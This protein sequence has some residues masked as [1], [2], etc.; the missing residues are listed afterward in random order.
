MP[1]PIYKGKGNP[2][3]EG[4]YRGVSV[5]GTLAKMYGSILGNRLRNYIITYNLRARS[6]AGGRPKQGVH[7]HLF[8]IQ[9]L[10]DL[11]KAPIRKG[12]RAAP[13]FMCFIDFEKGFDNVD[14]NLIWIRLEERGIHGKFLNAIK[15]VYDEVIIRVKTNGNYGDD[16]ETFL[17]VKQGDPL[18]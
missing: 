3:E 15:A 10:K 8:T 9:H 5:A 4:N 7:Q 6:Q 12:G 17:G 14:R 16:F 11:Y 18:V 2:D 1:P 13:L